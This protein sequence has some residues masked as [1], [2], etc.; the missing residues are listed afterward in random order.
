LDDA[1]SVLLEGEGTIALVDDRDLARYA[2]GPS[3]LQRITVAEVPARFGF[4]K[5]PKAA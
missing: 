5:E 4:V 3:T 1:G 2:D